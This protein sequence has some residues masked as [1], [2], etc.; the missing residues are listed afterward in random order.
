MNSDTVSFHGKNY[1]AIRNPS[2]ESI[3]G[4]HYIYLRE[5]TLS[6]QIYRY[7]EEF[8]REVLTCDMS[9]S[10]GDTFWLPYSMS[11]YGSNPQHG[12][13]TTPVPIIAD[14]VWFLNGLKYI[15]FA[16]VEEPWESYLYGN[17]IDIMFIEGIGPN[18][19]PFGWCDGYMECPGSCYI[20]GIYNNYLASEPLLLC[21]YKNGEQ[22][23]MTDER[24]GCYQ[25]LVNV[26][27]EEVISWRLYP[28]PA[29]NHLTIKIDHEISDGF[30]WITDLYGRVMYT[31]PIRENTFKLNLGQYSAGTYIVTIRSDNKLFSKKIIKR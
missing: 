19:S 26:K 10:L 8:D 7:D 3:Y 21:V 25:V 5:D 28:N 14:S 1:F 4:L 16:R 15:R 9:L 20:S 24:A 12:T 11:Y 22:V 31:Q 23:Y 17:G 6:G 2:H 18:Y 27:E 13:N 29:K 30:L